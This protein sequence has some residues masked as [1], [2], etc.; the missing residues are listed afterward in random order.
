MDI[1]D[2]Q[3]STLDT[4]RQKH[5]GT[6]AKLAVAELAAKSADRVARSGFVGRSKTNFADIRNKRQADRIAI[7]NTIALNRHDL[8]AK[9][10]LILEQA[11]ARNR[12]HIAEAQRR[13]NVQD[14]DSQGVAGLSAFNPYRA[15]HHRQLLHRPPTAIVPIP[16]TVV[17]F[18]DKDFPR[19]DMGRGRMGG[20]KGTHNMLFA[21][22]LHGFLLF[23]L[24]FSG[25]VFFPSVP[26]LLCVIL[27]QSQRGQK[28]TARQ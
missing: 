14:F 8:F 4:H 7:T 17:G 6:D 16:E 10:D 26:H 13:L 15:G 20:V 9:L 5:G 12:D 24:S 21:D 1:F 22:C 19:L 3:H 2:G 27:Y 25:P 11:V 18:H 28:A 23:I